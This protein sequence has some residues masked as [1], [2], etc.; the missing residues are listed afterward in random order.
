MPLAF[1]WSN[2]FVTIKVNHMIWNH[3]NLMQYDF[4]MIY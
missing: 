2:K 3:I 4:V 1:P